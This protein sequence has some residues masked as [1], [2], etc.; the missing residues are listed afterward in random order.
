MV[1]GVCR[2]VLFLPGNESLKGKRS[3]VRSLLG[4]VR[5][6]F[7]VAAAEV[8]ELDEHEH[9]ELAFAVVS[10]DA[11]HANG[12]LDTI[13]AFCEKNTDAQLASTHVELVPMG[14]RVGD[15]MR[16]LD[17]LPKSWREAPE[18]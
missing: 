11:R 8:G 2:V 18:S 6:K 16:E 10:N 1:V 5:A 4:R 14:K 13:A 7:N 17:S 12:M 3:V 15:P 9:A